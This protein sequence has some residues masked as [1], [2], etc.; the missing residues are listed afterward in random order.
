MALTTHSENYK[1]Q[2]TEYTLYTTNGTARKANPIRIMSRNGFNLGAEPPIP[3][4][5]FHS[6]AICPT[7]LNKRSRALR[8]ISGMYSVWTS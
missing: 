1:L 5:I 2:S 3:T 4:P 7:S 6:E 8:D